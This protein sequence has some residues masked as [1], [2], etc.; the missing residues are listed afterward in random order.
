MKRVVQI[1]PPCYQATDMYLVT[2]VDILVVY[3]YIS[4]LW[5]LIEWTE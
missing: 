4:Y 5:I 1:L 3:K 2:V